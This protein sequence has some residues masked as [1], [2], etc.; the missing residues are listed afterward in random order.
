MQNLLSPRNSYWCPYSC[1]RVH[2]LYCLLPPNLHPSKCSHN[3]TDWK[4]VWPRLFTIKQ[5]LLSFSK[6]PQHAAPV[7][8][9]IAGVTARRQTRPEHADESRPL[10]S[11]IKPR[12]IVLPRLKTDVFIAVKPAVT[13][14]QKLKEIGI[15][16]HTFSA[17][18]HHQK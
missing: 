12:N 7:P 15:M 10:C 1:L 11:R 16:M 18:S 13:G 17:S 14:T 9:R 8:Q 6:T 4:A 5:F 3:Q 2:I